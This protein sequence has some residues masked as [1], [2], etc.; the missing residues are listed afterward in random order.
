MS[1]SDGSTVPTHGNILTRFASKF[2]RKAFSVNTFDTVY[3]VS[4]GE[5]KR[6]LKWFHLMLLGVGELRLSC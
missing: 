5:M 4:G 3:D 1:T 2:I 6:S